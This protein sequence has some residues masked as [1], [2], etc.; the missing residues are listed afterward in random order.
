MHYSV[1]SRV[2][3]I[4]RDRKGTSAPGILVL[5][6]AGVFGLGRRE[7]WMG[8]TRLGRAGNKQTSP[9]H[10]EDGRK[11]VKSLPFFANSW[12]S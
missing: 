12:E 2:I 8:C 10:I 5:G 3:D 1:S 6:S 7:I 11:L 4:A 9:Y